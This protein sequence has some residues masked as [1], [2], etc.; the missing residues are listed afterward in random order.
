M[1]L[2]VSDEAKLP[3]NLGTCPPAISHGH[4]ASYEGMTRRE[5]FVRDA[6]RRF[7]STPT[8]PGAALRRM[9]SASGLCERFARWMTLMLAALFVVYGLVVYKTPVASAYNTVG[10]ETAM[11][12][13]CGGV[14][15]RRDGECIHEWMEIFA[16]LYETILLSRSN[17]A[18]SEVSDG[19]P[20]RLTLPSF[21]R[22]G[23]VTIG[24]TGLVFCGLGVTMM[25]MLCLRKPGPVRLCVKCSQLCLGS[26]LSLYLGL[27]CLALYGGRWLTAANT[28]T[29]PW[30]ATAPNATVLLASN[31]DDY[32]GPKQ[33]SDLWVD[34][35]NLSLT[36]TTNVSGVFISNQKA[37]CILPRPYTE[38][39]GVQRP[40]RSKALLMSRDQ[41]SG[42]EQTQECY[43]IPV[44]MYREIRC[45]VIA[46]F[47][48]KHP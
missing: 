37:G 18:V 23:L 43:G 21:A 9:V 12:F 20:Y 19:L 17:P 3:L 45:Q 7:R 14:D 44:G 27:T 22:L 46:D 25:L 30:V 35:L 15:H 10:L 11:S 31:S 16:E 42:S 48:Y 26:L 36:V 38:V 13:L 5:C 28:Q 33:Y 29:T 47:D 41:V 39:W 40:Q 2:Q 4:R 24:F 6:R 1:P 34:Y 8:L 32:F